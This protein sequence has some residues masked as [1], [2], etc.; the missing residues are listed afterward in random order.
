MADS[1]NLTTT[2][3]SCAV[4]VGGEAVAAGTTTSIRAVASAAV[5]PVGLWV[6][7]VAVDVAVATVVAVVD[8][9]ATMASS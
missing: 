5:H 4:A 9:K 6:S 1:A 2:L 8:Q 3:P 7:A